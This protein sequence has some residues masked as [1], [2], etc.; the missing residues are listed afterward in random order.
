MELKWAR[1]IVS[2]QRLKHY[3]VVSVLSMEKGE[4]NERDSIVRRWDLF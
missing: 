4:A 2:V 3:L 1:G